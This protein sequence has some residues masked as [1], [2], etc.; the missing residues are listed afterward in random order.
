M[1]NPAYAAFPR[2]FKANTPRSTKQK[3]GTNINEADTREHYR[4]GGGV[5]MALASAAARSWSTSLEDGVCRWR[6]TW[7]VPDPGWSATGT[8]VLR[9]TRGDPAGSGTQRARLAPACT[10]NGWGAP[11]VSSAPA[12][13]E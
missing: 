13:L 8:A 4:A 9:E 3:P 2:P 12:V 7:E 1:G 5:P 6:L 11:V 10:S